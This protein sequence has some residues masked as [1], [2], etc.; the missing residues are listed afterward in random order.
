VGHSTFF[1]HLVS[2]QPKVSF[3]I[4]R[5]LRGG[6][7]VRGQGRIRVDA[8]GPMGREQHRS[9]RLRGERGSALLESAI[10]LPFLVV[11]VFG[12]VELGFLFRS[13]AIVNTSTRSGARLA[14]SQYGSATTVADQ[15]NVMDNAAESVERDLASRGG[16]DTPVQ[17]WIY[18][19]DTDGFPIG[20]G[21]FSSCTAPCFIYTWNSGTSKF[22]RQSGAW[23][24]P[25]VCGP[26][27]DSVGVYVRLSHAPLGFSNF[28]GTLTVNEKTVMR[29]EP[30]NADSSLCPQGS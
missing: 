25:V 20:K 1:T 29:L 9:R 17:L 24:N 10:V 22:V 8:G 7:T 3:T 16:V 13:A 26:S 23:A 12:I 15:R 14:A 18:K 2:P 21:S 5:T 6:V 27:H 11:M 28:I 19:A 4:E 30:P